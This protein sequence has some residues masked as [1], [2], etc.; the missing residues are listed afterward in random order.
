MNPF[1]F[2]IIIISLSFLYKLLSVWIQHKDSRRAGERASDEA[3]ATQQRLNDMEERV[4]VLERIVTDE[5]FDLKRQFRD[6]G[7]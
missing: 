7:G 2:V 1:E 5:R 3:I 4:R 6:L